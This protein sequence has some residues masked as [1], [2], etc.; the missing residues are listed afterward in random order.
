MRQRALTSEEMKKYGTKE[1]IA[2]DFRLPFGQGVFSE[3]PVSADEWF[4]TLFDGSLKYTSSTGF[5]LG[6]NP[7][8]LCAQ[9]HPFLQLVNMYTRFVYSKLK[10]VWEGSYST[11][12]NSSLGFCYSTDGAVLNGSTVGPG[13]PTDILK[14]TSYP[15]GIVTPIWH[16]GAVSDF[17]SQLDTGD[18]FYIDFPQSGTSDADYR[19]SYQGV[20]AVVNGVT[21]PTGVTDQLYGIAYVEGQIFV[22]DLRYTGTDVQLSKTIQRGI[23]H[24]PV[25]RNFEKK[26]LAPSGGS[27]VERKGEVVGEH[28]EPYVIPV[29]IAKHIASLRLRGDAKSLIIAQA[30]EE[31]CRGV[32]I[33]EVDCLD[34]LREESGVAPPLPHLAFSCPGDPPRNN[35]QRSKSRDR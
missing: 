19:Q 13:Y 35:E 7:M 11:S 23:K 5:A 34:P 15:T 6:V 33:S 31:L 29:R 30:V 17:T 32:A 2:I 25:P 16:P 9:G 28:K 14:V 26:F 1:G 21:V 22:S 4:Q 27:A 24:F 20:L 10:V 18:M 12:S 3:I 8:Q